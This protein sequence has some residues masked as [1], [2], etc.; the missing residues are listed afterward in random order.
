MRAK[1]EKVNVEA[2]KARD[3]IEQHGYDVGIAETEDT[4]RA[5]VPAVC[6]A[7]CAQT[8]EEAL[9]RAGIEASSELR[10]PE[11][12]YLPP[13]I[14]ASDFPS[15][16]DEVTSTVADPVEETQPQDPLPPNQQEQPKEPE[17]LKGTSSDK[18]TEV[19]Q[20]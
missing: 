12:I 2:K 4:L 14:R 10:R 11:N 3:E 19:P 8:W 7:Y 9:N 17:V 5:E 20:D 18:A 15:N 1:V 6:R 13:A 16:Q